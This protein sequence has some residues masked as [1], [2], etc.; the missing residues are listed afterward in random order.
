MSW[1]DLTTLHTGF[2]R[3]GRHARGR[4]ARGQ[5]VA[6]L[7][8][9]L[10]ALL[11]LLLGILQIGFLVFTQLGLTNAAREASRNAAAIPVANV[12]QASPAAAEYFGRLTNS[13]DGFLKRNVGGYDSSRLDTAAG[14]GT[15]VCYYSILDASNAPAVMA[16]VT[17][18][19]SHPI[20]IPFVGPIIDGWDG[21][22]DGGVTLSVVEDIR[23]GNVVLSSTDIGNSGSPTC[24]P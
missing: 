14:T 17:V 22:N 7:A 6:E 8:L 4:S 1:G 21:T 9:I 20:F 2:T 3:R 23:V 5:S 16:S 15:R 13:T 12:A 18:K 10:P 19:Y 11:L 24:N